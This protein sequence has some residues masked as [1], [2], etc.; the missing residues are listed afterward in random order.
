MK[1]EASNKASESKRRQRFTWIAVFSL[2]LIVWGLVS[3]SLLRRST[4]PTDGEQELL[5]IDHVLEDMVNRAVDAAVKKAIEQGQLVPK[6]SSF[7]IGA[8]AERSL[9]HPKKEEPVGL[10]STETPVQSKAVTEKKSMMTG[11]VGKESPQVKVEPATS[12]RQRS[13]KEVKDLSSVD[14]MT[15]CGLGHRLTKFADA[16]FVAKKLNWALKSFWGFCDRTEVFHYLFG[17]QPVDRL[18]NVT[19]TGRYLRLN[20][21]VDGFHDLKR[22]GPNKTCACFFEKAEADVEFYTDLR[23]RFR[24]ASQVAEFRHRYF[25]GKTV[26]GVH[27]RAGN[28]ETGHFNRRRRSVGDLDTWLNNL[29]EGLLKQKKLHSLPDTVLFLATDT[30]SMIDKLGNLLKDEM[31]VITFNQTRPKEGEGVLFGERG[32]VESS[33]EKCLDGWQNTVTDMVLLSHADV[34]IAAR[35]SSFTQSMPMALV[36]ARP[37]EQRTTQKAFCEVNPEATEFQCFSDI[38]D[39]CCNGRTDFSLNKIQQQDYFHLSNWTVSETQEA[40]MLERGEPCIPTS[41]RS[42]QRCL[43][44]DWGDF[45]VETD[46]SVTVLTE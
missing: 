10:S 6:N 25:E 39:W 30:P 14:Y 29:V 21:E 20:N 35:P 15:C 43:P 24:G 31:P 45:R 11:S 28:G 16:N 27:I 17:P 18:V 3:V 33:G 40:R 44:Y 2:P 36:Y 12:T 8:V 19:D 26:I 4:Q 42:K 34:V 7:S 46:Y 22:R 5:V 23:Q 32:K 37:K 41:P 38:E 9:I 13:L 1:A